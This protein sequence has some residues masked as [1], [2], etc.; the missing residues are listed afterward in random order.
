MENPEPVFYF[1]GD[2][3]FAALE[4][5]I[6]G[7]RVSVDVEVYYFAGDRVGVR[8]SD[9]LIRKA[10]EGVRV[11]L[12]Y[13][14]IGCRG[15]SDD[16][17]VKLDHAGVQV[18][19]F[20]PLLDLG[21]NLTRRT[22]RKFFLIDGTVGFLGGFNLADEYSREASGDAAWRDTGVRLDE[23]PLVESLRKLFSETW[24]GV[25]RKP[26]DFLRRRRHPADWGKPRAEIVPN[27]GWQRK[28][29]IRQEYLSAFVHAKKSIL[30]A[31]PYFVPDRGLRRALRRAARR[32]VD[33]RVLTAGQSD[34]PIARWAGR[35]VYGG[36][37]RAGVRIFEYSR[38]VLHAKSA[39]ADGSWYTVG[40]ANID[41]LSFFRN[42][43]VNL[44]GFDPHRAF[45]LEAQFLKDVQYAEEVVWE[46][47]RKR[48]WLE[49]L[50]ERVF[51]WM[52]VWL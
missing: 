8:F 43:E 47:W 23:A 34:V 16:F 3:Y 11:R 45:L 1:E 15:T 20:H 10:S 37:L 29:L 2:D 32:G 50:R 49:K 51:F 4:R 39:T 24:D 52:R 30:I 42:Q 48:S 5:A 14:A 31:N 27:Y 25:H 35:A 9:L 13:D 46:T 7:A 22:H 6:A 19:V 17:F 28:S 18:K 12:I 44:F 41:H 26:R 38:R 36:L 33:V 40:T 21:V